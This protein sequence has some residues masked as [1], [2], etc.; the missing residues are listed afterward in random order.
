VFLAVAALVWWLAH[1]TGTFYVAGLGSPGSELLGPLLP[2]ISAGLVAALVFSVV[3]A[4]A[5]SWAAGVAVAML[6]ALP[7]FVL[8]H[9][10]SLN[11]PPLEVGVMLTLAVMLYAPRFSLAYG[12]IAAITAVFVSPAAVGLP[13]AAMCWAVMTRRGIGRAWRRIA[14]SLAPLLLSIL[15]ARWVGHAWSSA[16][17][18]LGWRGHLDDGLHAAGVVIG[19][20][21]APTL[22]T[23]ALRW[24]AIADLTLLMVAV[25]LVAWRRL[26]RLGASDAVTARFHPAVAV[27]A[28][29]LAVGLA[30]RWL[31]VPGSSSLDLGAVFPLVV[32]ALIA[33]VGS[34]GQL[35]SRWPRW[36]K[37]LCLVVLVGWVQAALR[38]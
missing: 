20:Q 33:T 10:V 7:G 14:V 30:L 5:G 8:L 4:G 36:G 22:T 12:T 24:F 18:T 21:L 25:N 15:L 26:R 1:Q 32:L 2:A 6:L 17:L 34:I 11:G 9:R 27:T 13:L 29:G 35:W 23:P 3:D 16:E 38:A 19:D 37:V 31:F 28:A